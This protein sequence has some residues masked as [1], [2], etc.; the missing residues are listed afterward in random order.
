MDIY[1]EAFLGKVEIPMLIAYGDADIGI[2]KIDGSMKKWLERVNKT[3]NK[4]TQ[5]SAIK[6][7]SHSFKGYED[8]LS[9]SVKKFIKTIN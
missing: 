3:K 5:I 4:N 6:E 8:K 2:L 1:G 7:A 9:A